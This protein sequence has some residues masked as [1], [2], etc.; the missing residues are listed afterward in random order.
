MEPEVPRVLQSA[1]AVVPTL[2]VEVKEEA[3]VLSSSSPI[4]EMTMQVVMPLPKKKRKK[5]FN[6]KDVGDVLDAFKEPEEK[7]STP[8]SAVTQTQPPELRPTVPAA[9]PTEES[10]ETWEKEDKLEMENIEPEGP[11][12][13][14]QKYQYKEE[15][16]KPINPKEKRY[17]RVPTALPGHQC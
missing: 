14:E 9:P 8:E 12:S 10:E 16:W 11:K 2:V 1:P 7:E 6:N 3:A 5:D 4:D 17:D 15:H 13:A